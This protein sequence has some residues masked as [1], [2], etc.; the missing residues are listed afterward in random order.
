M[1]FIYILSPVTLSLFVREVCGVEE[2]VEVTGSQGIGDGGRGP[3]SEVVVDV[4]VGNIQRV[5]THLLMKASGGRQRLQAGWPINLTLNRMGLDCL[6]GNPV[7][8][9]N[10]APTMCWE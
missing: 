7:T 1:I 5:P 6:G 3:Y 9:P 8:Y 10:G 2:V 4:V